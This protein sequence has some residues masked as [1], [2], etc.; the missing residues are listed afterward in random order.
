MALTQIEGCP[1]YNA[2][3]LCKR[4]L[5]H[6][7][8]AIKVP[9]RG[10]KRGYL[11]LI[12]SNEKFKEKTGVQWGV[13]ELKESYP[14]FPANATVKQNRKTFFQFIAKKGIK[15]ATKAKELLKGI[16][17]DAIDKDYVLKL[18]D[19]IQEYNG[20]PF[21]TMLIHSKENYAKMN[22]EVHQK[23]M[24]NFE[25]PLV[26]SLPVN[27]YF[28]KQEKFRKLVADCLNI[29]EYPIITTN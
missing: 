13:P 2:M 7:T 11:D 8:L 26:M 15:T 16:F 6:N 10:D 27:R 29:E 5:G 4:E 3:Q 21:K 19:E 1:L 23:F 17:F 24:D 22:N 28:V 25:Q 20:T 14:T 18:K 9:F 12:Y